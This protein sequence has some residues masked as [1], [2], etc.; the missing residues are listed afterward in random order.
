MNKN[1]EF[2]N[3]P[4]SDNLID[5]CEHG[6]KCY[7]V[8]AGLCLFCGIVIDVLLICPRFIMY[9]CN[10]NF[11]KSNN[12]ISNSDTYTENK[13]KNIIKNNYINNEPK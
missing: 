9:K 7:D 5:I 4:L 13:K 8:C 1:I 3:F 11:C 12:T 10:C 6:E 2:S